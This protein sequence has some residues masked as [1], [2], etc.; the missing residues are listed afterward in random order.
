MH[1]D[2]NVSRGK[3]RARLSS[4]LGVILAVGLFALNLLRVGNLEMGQGPPIGVYDAIPPALSRLAFSSGDGYR[5]LKSVSDRFYVAMRN[6]PHDSITIERAISAVRRLGPGWIS[7]GTI[8]LGSDDKG[9]VDFVTTS[10]WLFGYHR[11]GVLFLYF[12]LLGF[13]CAISLGAQSGAFSSQVVVGA[14]LGS[15]HLILPMVFHFQQLPSML[16]LL[17]LPG[18]SLVACFHSLS[19]SQHPT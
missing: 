1:T 19:F 8:L 14:F 6:Q 3:A 2:S 13:S 5:S 11:S 10:F 15:H 4:L 9:I 12:I 16:A 7:R 17:F 18:L